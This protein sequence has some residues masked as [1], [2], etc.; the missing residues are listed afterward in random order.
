MMP[1]E[2][3]ISGELVLP[4]VSLPPHAETF[5]TMGCTLVGGAIRPS[6]GGSGPP[7]G[8]GGSPKEEEAKEGM[9][10]D[11]QPLHNSIYL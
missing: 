1:L 6:L 2:A 7:G 3:G 4:P 10:P 11:P 9:V 8:L 5:Y